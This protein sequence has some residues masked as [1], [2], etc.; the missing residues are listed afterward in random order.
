[1][2]IRPTLIY[3]STTNRPVAPRCKAVLEICQDAKHEGRLVRLDGGSAHIMQMRLRTAIVAR[4]S[5]IQGVL[6]MFDCSVETAFPASVKAKCMDRA[7]RGVA[8]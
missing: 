1:M 2:P 8:R 5:H 6:M 7:V 4:D 3:F